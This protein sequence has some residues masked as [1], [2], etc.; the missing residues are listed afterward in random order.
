MRIGVA[1]RYFFEHTPDDI[2]RPVR[3]ALDALREAG[4]TLVEVDVGWPPT[5]LADAGFYLGEEGGRRRRATGRSGVPSWAPR[6]SATARP[7]GQIAP[8][9]PPARSSGGWSTARATHERRARAGHHLVASPHAALHAAPVG[10]LP[11]PSPAMT[12]RTSRRPC[13]G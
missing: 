9:T 4:A 11:F 12:R 6:S 1:E 3:D 2:A 13:A 10:T 5:G 7:A 8:S